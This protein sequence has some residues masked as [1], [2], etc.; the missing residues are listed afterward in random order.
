MND[1]EKKPLV[2]DLDQ[3][4]AG[5]RDEVAR[6]PGG[7]GILK[8]YA[9]GT[10]TAGCPVRDVSEE[11]NP[12]RIIH[13]VLL[14]MREDVLDSEFIWYCSTC[15]TCQERCPQGVKITDIMTA[16]KN[17]AARSGKTPKAY[18]M[19]RNLILEMG[20]LYE[21]DDFD[22][23]KRGKINLPA[24]HMKWDE[25]Q[26]MYESVTGKSMKKEVEEV[27]SQET[28]VVKAVKVKPKKEE[29]E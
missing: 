25:L 28:V 7:E 24:I 15:F 16:L 14:G 26:T 4:D 20:R 1:A 22:N 17:M 9:C 5:F 11:Y 8:C 19:Q 3:A 18:D 21:L 23:K 2:V 29:T 27:D 12:R 13:Q 10:C 6:E